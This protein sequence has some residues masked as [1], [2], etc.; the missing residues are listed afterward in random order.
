MAYCI[1]RALV[2]MTIVMIYH[3]IWIDSRMCVDTC[4]TFL[5]GTNYLSTCYTVVKTQLRTP[6]STVQIRGACGME[7]QWFHPV[8]HKYILNQRRLLYLY[9]TVTGAYESKK[10]S[11]F[12]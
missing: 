3:L 5:S 8:C 10:Q 4:M 9:I 6:I 2:S 1:F 12:Y 7:V 11:R